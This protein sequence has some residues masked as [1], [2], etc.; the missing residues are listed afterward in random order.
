MK[1]TVLLLFIF[2][3]SILISYSQNKLNEHFNNLKDWRTGQ[4]WGIIHP[5]KTWYY[6]SED[7]INIKKGNL[8]LS[9]KYAP[10]EVTH[11]GITYYPDFARGE[12]ESKRK[13]SKGV[14]EFRCFIPESGHYAI[15]LWGPTSEVDI[16]ESTTKEGMT[17]AN[18]IHWNKYKERRSQQYN[19]SI[20]WHTFKLIWDDDLTFL[21]DGN[22][23]R[24][25][26]NVD[27]LDKEMWLVLSNTLYKDDVLPID[28][29]KIDYIKHYKP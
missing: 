1:R 26:K 9:V 16:V 27:Y 11:K 19:V 29:F 14:Y 20:G 21:L 28:A 22:V 10:K 25:D 24:H 3:Q 8:E 18:H 7:C 4:H 23:I 15:W 6:T 12:L 17:M 5:Q 2:F 13:F